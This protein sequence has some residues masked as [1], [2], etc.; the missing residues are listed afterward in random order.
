MTRRPEP[1][2]HVMNLFQH[3]N[4]FFCF[5]QTHLSS[6]SLP[7]GRQAQDGGFRCGLN[8]ESW[9]PAFAGM[10]YHESEKAHV[11]YVHLSPYFTSPQGEGFSPSPKGTLKQSSTI[12][13]RSI[14]LEDR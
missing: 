4:Y 6:P 3:L 1:N 13:T 7:T 2:R 8:K 14:P 10:T 11:H 9:I 12:L 5:Q